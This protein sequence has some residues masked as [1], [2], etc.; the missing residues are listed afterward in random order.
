MKDG[1]LERMSIDDFQLP[2]KTKLH[3]TRH[4]WDCFQGSHLDFFISF[5]SLSGVSG[6]RAQANYAAGNTGQ[7]ALAQKLSNSNTHVMSL[8]LGMIADANV[9]R[10]KEGQARSKALTR[11]GMIPVP[12]ESLM[13]LFDYAISPQ[14]RLDQCH[15]A[16]MG[17][18]GKSVFEASNS[19]PTMQSALFSHVRA[20]YKSENAVTKS[21]DNRSI[22]EIILEAKD[23][24]EVHQIMSTAIGRRLSDLLALGPHTLASNEALGDFGLD[25]LTSIEIKGWISQEFES[26]VQASE[27]L[28]ESSIL[29][30][31]R[32]V[33]SRSSIVKRNPNLHQQP[34]DGIEGTTSEDAQREPS[35]AMTNEGLENEN[36][37][38]TLPKLP[39]PDLE[40]SLDLYL[41]SA[42]PFIPDEAYERTARGAQKLRRGKGQA[43]QRKLQ[44]RAADPTIE[45]WQ[46]DLQVSG[47]YLRRRDPVHPGG[48][49]YGSHLL[50]TNP[51]SQAE[52]AAV[53]SAAAYQFMK[54]IDDDELKQDLLNGEP[55]CMDSLNW[56]FNTNRR[57]CVGVDKVERHP[58]N[59]YCIALR[60]GHVCKIELQNSDGAELSYYALL[61]CFEEV[62]G[63]SEEAVLPIVALS[64]GNRD[65]WAQLRDSLISAEPN[66][67]T[68]MS[69]ERAAFVVCLDDGSPCSSTERCNQFLLGNPANRWADKALQ[70]V[71][72]EN[73]MSGYVCEHSKLDGASLKQSNEYITNAI[74][75][76]KPSRTHPTMNG[77]LKTLY[78]ELPLTTDAAMT[79]NILRVQQNFTATT[80]PAS[81]VEWTTQEIGHNF[82]RSHKLPAK[83]GMQL[84]IQLAALL[85]YGTQH[86]SWE[87]LTMMPFQLGRL[88]WMQVVSRPILA[89]CAHIASL[90]PSDLSSPESLRLLR[91]ATTAHTSTMTRIARG[92]GF[93]AH[94]E[95]LRELWCQEES[96]EGVEQREGV[97]MQEDGTD[98]ESDEVAEFFKDPTW[99]MMRVTSTRMIKTDASEGMLAP[100]A[101]FLMPDPRSLWVHYEIFGE[102]VRLWVL[103]SGEGAREFVGRLEEAVGRVRGV[104]GK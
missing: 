82:L 85:H 18:D 78:T 73:G 72:C 99:E 48:T 96:S 33:A 27:I 41:E 29:A 35:R 11:Q 84:V 52:R 87:I 49:F 69:I 58:Q 42:Q 26:T 71:V 16:V 67:N 3:G 43:L 31:G 23:M 80:P 10:D 93:A 61:Q 45:N 13:A 53:I 17:I 24:S 30:L 21:G 75:A 63:K 76:H 91:E 47:V 86:P 89:F 44:E 104:L 102:E 98:R 12:G 38:R 97:E 1:V 46:H 50:S 103:G 14:A 28:D 19:T 15:Q 7:D 9:Y 22:R 74:L 57:P 79:E 60:R 81:F 55:M 8:D 94:L 25:S 36:M 2:L 70:F 101:G 66:Y 4:L 83:S 92:R 20:A 37:K 90:P 34:G 68:V 59:E 62:L 5:A 56:L 65:E 40:E 100:D 39:L 77:L 51:H 32:R 95:A 6:T 88:D 64:S 54:R